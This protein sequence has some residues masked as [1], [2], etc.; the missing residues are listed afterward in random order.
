MSFPDTTRITARTLACACA[1]ALAPA[2]L[3]AEYTFSPSVDLRFSADDNLQVAVEERALEAFDLRL[4]PALNVT[5]RGDRLQI[6][7]NTRLSFTR[8]D[9]VDFDTDDQFMSL[10]FLYGGETSLLQL[11]LDAQRQS[12]RTS[13]VLDSGFIG[14]VER[15]AGYTVRPSYV[16]ALNDLYRLTIG[17]S[18]SGQQYD[19]TLFDD[20]T[21][22]G[23]DVSLSRQLNE[24]QSIDL[25]LFG[26]EFE[27]EQRLAN[28][29]SPGVCDL[30]SADAAVFCL[31]SFNSTETTTVGAQLGYRH[32]LSERT[33]I[34]ISIGTRQVEA[35]DVNT[36]VVG[37]LLSTQFLDTLPFLPPQFQIF[38]LNNQLDMAD[39]N[40]NCGLT[41]FD[42]ET[43]NDSSGLIT[44][45]FLE[46][47]G[48]KIKWSASF[49][50]SISPVGLGFLIETDRIESRFEYRF[51]PRTRFTTRATIQQA[52]AVA[53]ESNFARDFY[54]I[55]STLTWRMGE[56]WTLS[57][58][59]RWRRQDASFLT[60]TAQ[61][62][63]GYVELG[64][65]PRG[66]K[67]S[68]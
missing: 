44:R 32:V 22:Y 62:F 52:A 21:N 35:R 59:I 61:S 39:A 24:R 45:A 41:G 29:N 2:A 1:V 67:V 68:R 11:D 6:I 7:S 53:S 55:N 12:Q 50:R 43:A 28:L 13:E 18:W 5:Y 9:D 38:A 54:S 14:G 20:Y 66:T 56:H 19:L 64:Y 40:G 30:P 34:G 58:G 48:E 42:L 33:E 51:S 49:E 23:F 65:R 3:A 4:A 46:N 60:G 26:S 63:S 31:S 15:V 57:P 16:R 25:T 27:T 37:C 17:A 36:E 10:S 47:T 8:F